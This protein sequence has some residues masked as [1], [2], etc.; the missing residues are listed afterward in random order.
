MGE[1]A[2][3]PQA[4]RPRKLLLTLPWVFSLQSFFFV[5]VH[6]TLLLGWTPQMLLWECLRGKD[7]FQEQ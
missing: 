1:K 7:C 2:A 5:N 4:G 6:L 3:D